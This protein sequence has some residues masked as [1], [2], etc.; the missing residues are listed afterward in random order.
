MV[1]RN[2]RD[3]TGPTSVHKSVYRLHLFSMQVL[4]VL[5]EHM[6]LQN[7]TIIRLSIECAFQK[8]V[9]VQFAQQNPLHKLSPQVELVREITK[10]SSKFHRVFHSPF[11][12]NLLKP[13]MNS[14]RYTI[15]QPFDNTSAGNDWNYVEPDQK[16]HA[17]DN[18]PI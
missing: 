2:G 15:P 13:V 12:T 5:Q 18:E 8:H 11:M 4:H 7:K 14:S 3:F 17:G 1:A 16:R 10:L 6:Y 9:H